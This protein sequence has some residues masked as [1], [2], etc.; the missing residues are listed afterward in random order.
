MA[1][2]TAPKNKVIVTLN[3]TDASSSAGLFIPDQ[4]RAK[5]VEG[6]VV[7]TGYDGVAVGEV[8]LLSGEYAGAVFEV[9]KVEYVTVVPEEILA[10]VG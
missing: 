9:D 8:L 7:A 2:L 4:A 1:Q 10:V 3:A 5:S 6:T